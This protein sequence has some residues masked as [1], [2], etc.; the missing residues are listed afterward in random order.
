MRRRVFEFA[1]VNVS[2][3]ELDLLTMIE[4]EERNGITGFLSRVEESEGQQVKLRKPGSPAGVD[5]YVARRKRLW[6]YAR[7][8]E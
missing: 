4:V 3:Q 7:D 6:L 1:E 8:I 2:A 5:Q